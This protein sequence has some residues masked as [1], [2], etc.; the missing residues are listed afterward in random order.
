MRPLLLLCFGLALSLAAPLTLPTYA[1]GVT[2]NLHNGS[3][4]N[5][6]RAITCKEGERILRNR[7]FWDVRRTDCRGRFFVY[8][9]WRDGR[10][11]EIALRARNGRVADM[12]RVGR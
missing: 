5:T 3:S 8:R 9:A 11:Y 7:G 12:R 1:Q 6:R 4:F 10:R 2:I